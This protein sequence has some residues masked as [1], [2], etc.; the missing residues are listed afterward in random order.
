MQPG[1]PIEARD[2]AAIE[3]GDTSAEAQADLDAIR[4]VADLGDAVVVSVPD[5]AGERE[6]A[7][8]LIMRSEAGWRLREWFD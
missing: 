3:R 7:S 5:V 6:P 1:S 2:R 8:L 4:V